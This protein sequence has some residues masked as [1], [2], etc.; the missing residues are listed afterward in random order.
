M[1]HTRSR[2][3]QGEPAIAYE[4]R[5]ATGLG[6]STELRDTLRRGVR[7]VSR[8]WWWSLILG[9]AWIWYGMFVLS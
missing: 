5:E 4:T 2:R 7:D 8:L 6:T 3:W 1:G 9:V